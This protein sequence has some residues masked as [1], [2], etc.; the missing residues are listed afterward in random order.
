MKHR[1]TYLAAA[2]V[3]ADLL[4]LGGVWHVS[5]TLSLTV[6]LAV[7]EVEQILSPLYP[8]PVREDVASGE[9]HR[10]ARPRS[11]VVLTGDGGPDG[12]VRGVA[13]ALARRDIAVLVPG[14]A[15]TLDATVALARTFGTPVHVE[16]VATFAQRSTPGDGGSTIAT[17]AAY[18]W[19]LLRV[20]HALLSA[21]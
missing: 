17:R 4:A 6:G 15:A 21:R 20:S 14:P 2:V 8:D 13:R 18:A 7:P 1:F 11:T 3:L 9:L 10:P 12:H 16:S 5:P 19:R